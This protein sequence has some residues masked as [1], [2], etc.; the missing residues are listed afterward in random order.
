MFYASNNFNRVLFFRDG[1][2]IYNLSFINFL[3]LSKNLKKDKTEK[4]IKC[5]ENNGKLYH[6]GNNYKK[7]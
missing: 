1:N 5:E 7:V 2:K 6:Q 4:N 3:P